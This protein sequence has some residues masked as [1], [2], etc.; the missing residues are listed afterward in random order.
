ML[1]IYIAAFDQLNVPYIY[2]SRWRHIASV[3]CTKLTGAP[4]CVGMTELT[5]MLAHCGLIKVS[6]TN[7]YILTQLSKCKYDCTGTIHLHSQK[8]RGLKN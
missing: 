4:S 1:Y 3:Q 6:Y 5:S 2:S 7:T 8:F